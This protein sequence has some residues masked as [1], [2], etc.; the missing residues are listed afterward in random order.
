MPTVW[1]SK[2]YS[3]SVVF[4]MVSKT[5][6]CSKCTNNSFTYNRVEHRLQGRKNVN[7]LLNKYS[8]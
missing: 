7:M 5:I 1:T 2:Q 4:K 3:F 8:V 6:V